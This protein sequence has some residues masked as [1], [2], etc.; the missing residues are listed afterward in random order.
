M[1]RNLYFRLAK[2]NIDTGTQT[3]IPY[4]FACSLSVMMFSIIYTISKEA[5]VQSFLGVKTLMEFGAIITAFFSMIFI[6][7]GNK[8]LIKNR[9]KEIGLYT[10]LGLEEKHIAGALFFEFFICYIVTLLLGSAGSLLFGKLCFLIL[11]KVSGIPAKI[12]Y[13]FSFSFFKQQALY[14]FVFFQ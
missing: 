11:Y 1:I 13:V 5:F 6:F 9:M 4:I 12:Q 14:S 3:Y 2:K 10:I 7:Y 8:F